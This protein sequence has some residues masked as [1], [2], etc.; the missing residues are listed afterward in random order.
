MKPQTVTVYPNHIA[1]NGGAATVR[2]VGRSVFV[3]DANM[4]TIRVPLSE[5]R[6]GELDCPFLTAERARAYR[7]A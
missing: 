5:F 7:N 3:S 6:P 1:A 2:V 4:R